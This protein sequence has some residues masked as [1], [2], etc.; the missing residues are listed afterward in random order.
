MLTEL[1][2]RIHQYCE[3]I[4]HAESLEEV[5]KLRVQLLGKQGELTQLLKMI[6]QLPPE[7]RPQMGQIVN[8]A[9]YTIQKTLEER[10]EELNHIILQN[11]LNTPSLDV[12]L[13]GRGMHLGTLHPLTRTR[14]QLEE[15]FIQAG[16]QLMSGPEI[17]QDALNFT[18]L[19][20]PEHHPAR[21]MHDTFYLKNQPN[22]LLR[23]HTSTVQI[24][25]LKQ[26][27]PPLRIIATGPVYRCDSDM[28]HTPMFHQLEGMVIN[29]AAHFSELKGLLTH[30]LQVFF[31]KPNLVSRFRSSYFPF[32]EPSAE[33]DIQC[34]LC[35]GQGCAV[36]S[37]T[38][39]LEILGC[40]MVHPNVLRN[41][42]IDPDQ[43]QGYAFGMGID[44]LTLLRY[45]IPDLRLLFENDMRLLKQIK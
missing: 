1:E 45:R 38:G 22:L 8:Q 6:G 15:L 11:Q 24:H 44:R 12:S 33:V 4:H 25:A 9:K 29:Q 2:S 34:V 40:G 43:Y 10:K 41:A 37:H 19:N 28:T 31:E 35:E 20:I 32:T 16:F 26:L 17:E 30:F 14:Y 39:W 5:E 36:C 18:A 13:P 42:N 7:E 23:T 27:T 21:A 3:L